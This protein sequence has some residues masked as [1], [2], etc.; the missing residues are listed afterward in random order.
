MADPKEILYAYLA[1]I[2]DGEGSIGLTRNRKNKSGRIVY[3][4]FVTVGMTAL[5]IPCLLKEIFG[6]SYYIRKKYS[7]SPNKKPLG[8]W[9]ISCLKAENVIKC[10]L[11]YL[12]VKRPQA[13]LALEYRKE[14]EKHRFKRKKNFDRLEEFGRKMKKLN[15][16]GI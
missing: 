10:L 13:E 7:Y 6:G 14:M 3:Y 16:R 15:K 9:S 12:R 4:I 1:G 5:E 11:P 2:I 8:M